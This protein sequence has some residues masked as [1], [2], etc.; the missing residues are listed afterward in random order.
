MIEMSFML[1]SPPA[2]CSPSFL[3][4]FD[5]LFRLRFLFTITHSS[6]I[7][8]C[9]AN[10][11][12]CISSCCW[13]P[14]KALSLTLILSWFFRSIFTSCLLYTSLL[15]KV[16]ARYSILQHCLALSISPVFISSFLPAHALLSARKMSPFSQTAF[17]IFFL[18][19]SL[20]QLYGTFLC[21][22]STLFW[23]SDRL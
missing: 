14:K 2:A 9:S 22:N 19:S 6:L 3:A 18:P 11:V 21:G 15:F 23:T 8:S 12:H 7:A 13:Q 16:F 20:S 17:F 1:T 4:W 5:L 10:R